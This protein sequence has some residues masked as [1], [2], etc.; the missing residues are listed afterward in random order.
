MKKLINFLLAYGFIFIFLGLELLSF[1]LVVNDNYFQRSAFFA[2]CSEVS[3]VVYEK[4]ED[5]LDYL[6]LRSVNED[7]AQENVTLRT[8]LIE[9][10][11][12][13]RSMA[14]SP[15]NV[16]TITLNPDEVYTCYSAKVINNSTDR[17][18]NYI[19]LNRGYKDGLRQ[20]MCVISGRGVVGI[21]KAVSTHFAVVMPILNTKTQISCKIKGKGINPT[22]TIGVVKDIGSLVWYGGDYRYAYMEQ[23]PRHVPIH[24][25]DQVVTSGY[26]DFFPEDLLIGTIE[27]YS[28]A[29]NDNYY[30]IKVRLAVNFKTLSYVE[31]L[32]YQYKREQESLETVSEQ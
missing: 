23:V 9:L 32:N 22:D 21:V 14:Q 16:G 1:L 28:K 15:Y 25:G 7:L 4:E 24:R 20:E 31:I 19:T 8:K 26:S 11:N 27:S 18:N 13:C 3:G 30:E 6:D 2:F 12:R 5:V 17:I 10:D 29:S